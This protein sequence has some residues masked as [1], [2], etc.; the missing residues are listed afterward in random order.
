MGAGVEFISWGNSPCDARSVWF[1]CWHLLALGVKRPCPSTVA[2]ASPKAVKI[3]MMAIA[4]TKMTA[5]TIA[6]F[7]RGPV[8]QAAQLAPAAAGAALVPP[9]KPGPVAK[10][11]RAVKAAWPVSAAKAVSA[12]KAAADRV[13]AMGSCRLVRTATT[14]MTTRPTHAPIPVQQLAAEMA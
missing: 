14:A 3:V 5:A 1:S 7:P 11:E 2:T 10:L 4:S 6:P 13:V 9:V 12:V 8:A